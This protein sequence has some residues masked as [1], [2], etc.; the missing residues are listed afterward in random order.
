MILY[1]VVGYV[2]PEIV[3]I[4]MSLGWQHIP[5]LVLAKTVDE[6]C[7][8]YREHHLKNRNLS[9]NWSVTIDRCEYVA[10]GEVIL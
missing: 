2:L 10:E 7:V 1:S 8:K 4:T 3:P 6:A 5:S 9:E